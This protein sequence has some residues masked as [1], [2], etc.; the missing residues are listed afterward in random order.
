MPAILK[1]LIFKMTRG[2][3]RSG[4]NNQLSIVYDQEYR[5]YVPLYGVF[6][7]IYAELEM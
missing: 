3:K 7:L 6:F 5:K 4:Q 2:V 1:V